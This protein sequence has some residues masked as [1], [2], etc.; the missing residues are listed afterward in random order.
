MGTVASVMGSNAGPAISS[1]QAGQV[2][3]QRGNYELTATEAAD[4]T[5]NIRLVKLPAGH[6]IVSLV[7]EID[8]IDSGAAG[9]LAIGVEDTVGATTNATLCATGQSCQAA[10]VVRLETAA[11]LAFAAADNDRYITVG[12]ETA[13]GTGVAGGIAA[14][15]TSRPELGSQFE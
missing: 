13:A 3:V 2:T 1:A 5:L 6:R 15:L 10:A 11:M 9:E 14:T 8:D 7:V 12:I 4:D